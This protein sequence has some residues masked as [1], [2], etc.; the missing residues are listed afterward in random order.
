MDFSR[1]NYYAAISDDELNEA[2]AASY[3]RIPDEVRDAPYFHH[4]NDCCAWFES[5]K[6]VGAAVVYSGL[7]AQRRDANGLD[8][9]GLVPFGRGNGQR[10]QQSQHQGG[11]G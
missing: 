4:S 5:A 7:H 2:I 3:R 9:S 8:D 11:D 10:R 1:L 6:I